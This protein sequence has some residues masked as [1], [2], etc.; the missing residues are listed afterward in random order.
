MEPGALA[1]EASKYIAAGE[2]GHEK[3]LFDLAKR[4]FRH[5]S[6]R[7]TACRVDV[8]LF[9]HFGTIETLP[10]DGGLF[11]A[12]SSASGCRLC[13]HAVLHVDIEGGGFY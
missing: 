9:C 12:R 8:L 3:S 11:G 2:A 7:R 6:G 13:A 5:A 1:I 10:W 4:R